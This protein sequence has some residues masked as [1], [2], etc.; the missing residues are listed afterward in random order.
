MN[1]TFLAAAALLVLAASPALA[2]DPKPVE[3]GPW[4]FGEVLSLNLS[5]STFS[6]NWTGG[7]KGSIVWVL[8]SSSTAER[9]FTKRFNSSS[10]LTLAYGQTSRQADD[11]SNPGH[12]TWDTPDKTTDQIL[13]ESV[14]RITLDA[15]VDP[16]FALRAESQFADQGN[17]AGT[18][19]VNPVK[20]KETAGIARVLYK[21][22]DGQVLTRLGFGF[23]QTLAR[24]ITGVNPLRTT[25]STAND[26]GFEW[27]TDV[28][29]PLLDKKVLWTGT[30]LVFQPVFF[31]GAGKLEDFDRA[32][33]TPGSGRGAV[34]DFW[35]TANVNAQSTFAAQVTKSMSVNLFAQWVY[36]KFD[37]SAH[38]DATAPIAA[39]VAEVDRNIRRA[40][41]FKETLALGFTYRLF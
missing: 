15:Y 32:A 22:A 35:K 26:G 9:Q 14:G 11:P 33:I 25:S 20:L 24:T 4:K 28:K 17:P 8:G 31:S 38:L 21:D 19:N 10:T 23:R 6:T 27:Q 40:G 18:L 39:Q 7:D 36:V 29:R 5:Q 41:Q 16:Y 37:E 34:A 13:F 2:A 30:L 3:P 12:R 1:R